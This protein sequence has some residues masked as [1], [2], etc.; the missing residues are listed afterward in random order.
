MFCNWSSSSPDLT[1]GDFFLWGHVK[2]KVYVPPLSRTMDE[3]QEHTTEAVHAITQICCEE[4]GP[5]LIIALMFSEQQEGHT[6]SV[7][8]INQCH[9]KL[10]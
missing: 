2:D 3:L 5:S 7:F 6:L 4:S 9:M 10:C 8:D 1:E